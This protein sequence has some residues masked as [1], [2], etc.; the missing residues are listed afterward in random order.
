MT[1]NNEPFEWRCPTCGMPRE[2][3]PDDDPGGY[4]KDGAAHCCKG[5][6]EGTG[7]T[8]AKRREPATVE[9]KSPRTGQTLEAAG[10]AGA[11][12]GGGGGAAT[13]YAESR[14]APAGRAPTQEEI[15]DDPASGAFVQSLQ[16]ETKTIEP[17]DYGTEKVT[18]APPNDGG[19]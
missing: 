16:R 5:C 17:E 9:H 12:A 19:K 8:C 4:M 13:E 3:W 15:R 2:D 10:G 1:T 11:D 6:A 7:C 14:D 18:K